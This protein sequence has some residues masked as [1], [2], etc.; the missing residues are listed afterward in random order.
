MNARG[1]LQM[2]KNAFVN[3]KPTST[4]TV[5]SLWLPPDMFCLLSVEGKKVW[6]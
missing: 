6:R 5:L 2:V 1:L 4:T 3:R